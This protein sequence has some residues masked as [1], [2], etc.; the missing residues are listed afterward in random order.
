MANPISGS[1]QLFI[2]PVGIDEAVQHTEGRFLPLALAWRYNN[3]YSTKDSSCLCS[4]LPGPGWLD[5]M[6]SLSPAV[7]FSHEHG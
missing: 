3:N 2:C 6:G 5:K 1:Y 4:N 7:N